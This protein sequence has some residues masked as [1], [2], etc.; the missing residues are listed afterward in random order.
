VR[1]AHVLP[2]NPRLCCTALRQLTVSTEGSLLAH[3]QLPQ[4]KP[5]RDEVNVLTAALV[6]V[7]AA[8]L[9]AAVHFPMT[10]YNYFV[11]LRLIWRCFGGRSRS[12]ALAVHTQ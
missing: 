8:C 3:K 2:S 6:R 1:E 11:V 9:I 7:V 5:F 10:Y 4:L 12:V